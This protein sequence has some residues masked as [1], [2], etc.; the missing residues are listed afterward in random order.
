MAGEK[1]GYEYVLAWGATSLIAKIAK[2]RLG[3]A[4]TFSSEADRN[5]V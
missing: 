2:K 3:S 4:L 1:S 5:R